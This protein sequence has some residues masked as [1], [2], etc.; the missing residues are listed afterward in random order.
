M[1]EAVQIVKLLL[2]ILIAPII[3]TCILLYML[4]DYLDIYIQ[5]KK[6]Q[7]KQRPGGKHGWK[8]GIDGSGW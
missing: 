4:L 2:W 7:R 1:N 6:R 3:F 5:D 8:S